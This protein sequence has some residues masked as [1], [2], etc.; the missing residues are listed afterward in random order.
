MWGDAIN[1]MNRREFLKHAAIAA[2]VTTS[3]SLVVGRTARA[4][5][6]IQLTSVAAIVAK[7]EVAWEQS[8]NSKWNQMHPEMPWTPEDVSWEVI[9]EKVLA[10]EKAHRAPNLGYGWTG[11]T[12]D[13]HKIGIIDAPADYLGQAW[14]D[15]FAPFVL[16]GGDAIDGK[17]WVVPIQ[18]AVYGIVSR[19]DWLAEAGITK[20]DSITTWDQLLE[21][22]DRV[23]K[24]RKNYPFGVPLGNARNAAE[25]TD[26]IFRS[27]GLLH[28]ADVGPDK[29]VAYIQ[30][31]EFVS[32]LMKYVSPDAFGQ[33]YV[34]HRR[35]FATGVAGF[36][37]IGSYYFGEIYDTAKSL[38]TKDHVT[39]I[40]YPGGPK[41]VGPVTQ[42][43]LN[44]YYL[45]KNGPNKDAAVKL[46]DFLTLPENLMQWSL[47]LPPLKEWTV[48]QVIP[49]RLYG[50][51]E[52][53]WLEEQLAISRRVPV[54]PA[55]GYV[56]KDEI[57]QVFYE[58]LTDMLRGRKKPAA[59]YAVMA[60]KVPELIKKT[61]KS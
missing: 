43:D 25:K 55:Q 8:M 56:A 48:D 9:F 29:K 17:L 36:I 1:R 44:C 31:L 2:A 26:W 27:N 7:P 34:G 10:Y 40:P 15:R 52:R 19:R 59:V 21:A 16:K 12:A 35:A 42:S 39:T 57:Q 5:G 13:W 46:V 51:A 61:Q 24:K 32:K 3:G 6:A 20:P 33:D 23:S 30:V 18:A 41:G 47:G 38:M 22:L 11:F 53:W 37:S 14:L 58:N 4:A 45:M 49:K 28:L 60:A 50:E 54:L